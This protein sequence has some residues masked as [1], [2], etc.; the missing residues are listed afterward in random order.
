MT[1]K[2]KAGFCPC[3]SWVSHV[4]IP[5]AYGIGE[6]YAH[7]AAVMRL[8]QAFGPWGPR[9][10]SAY[11]YVAENKYL[12]R[13]W[14]WAAATL[15]IRFPPLPYL[16]PAAQGGICDYLTCGLPTLQRSVPK[17]AGIPEAGLGAMGNLATIEPSPQA[18]PSPS[19]TKGGSSEP[20]TSPTVPKP[21]PPRFA[22]RGGNTGSATEDSAYES[23]WREGWSTRGWGR[24]NSWKGK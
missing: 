2:A 1:Q 16:A 19:D 10:Y 23:D 17:I 21:S 13:D 3:C 24:S 18:F 20:R 7:K 8:W 4:A 5:G 11:S 6:H 9:P 22:P 14:D 15:Q 12:P